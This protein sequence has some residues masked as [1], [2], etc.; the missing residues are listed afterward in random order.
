MAQAHML[1]HHRDIRNWVLDRKGSPA[2]ARIRN[3]FGEE[4][5]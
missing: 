1:V 2:I 4:R 3:R 5:A